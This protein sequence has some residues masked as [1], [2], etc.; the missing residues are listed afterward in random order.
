ME[1]LHSSQWDYIGLGHYHVYRRIA[2]N[3]FYSGA[4]DYTSTN[5]WGEKVEEGLTGAAGKGFIEHDLETGEHTFHRLTPSRDFVDLRPISAR[6]LTTEEVNEAIAMV[7]EACPGGIDDKVVRLVIRD[8]PRH[9]T[10][11][12]DHQ[13]SLR[14]YLGRRALHFHL[15]PR[16]PEIIRSSAHGAPGRRPSL[17][18]FVRDKLR[19][20][21]LSPDVDRETLVD[22]GLRYLKDAEER[23]LAATDQS[24][25]ERGRL[26]ATQYLRLSNFR[27]HGGHVHHVRYRLDRHQS[28][29]TAP[30]SQR[31]WKPSRGRCTD[32]MLRAERRRRSVRFAPGA[33]CARVK[34]ELDF[35]LGGHRH[36]VERAAHVGGAVSR[37]ISDR[38]SRTHSPA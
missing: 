34:V 16:R 23:E 8:L 7:V 25:A 36:R 32:R 37:R 30:A 5:T 17:A 24:A 38:P 10:R 28:A 6:G 35:E 22:L 9:I 26:D 15:D 29:R 1:D 14:E 21:V 12:L 13:V 19:E 31:S 4:L 27:Q 20:R 3:Q 2:A 33:G 11:Q 18:E